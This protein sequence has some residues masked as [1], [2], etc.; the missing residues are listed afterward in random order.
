MR[1]D[2]MRKVIV[3]PYEYVWTYTNDEWERS[4]EEAKKDDRILT[5]KEMEGE[6]VR[7]AEKLDVPQARAI[8]SKM[9]NVLPDKCFVTTGLGTSINLSNIDSYLIEYI[10][11]VVRRINIISNW[12]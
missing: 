9:L 1:Y 10:Y 3:K 7:I 4:G 8:L 12:D 5:T 6:I 2:E 11:N